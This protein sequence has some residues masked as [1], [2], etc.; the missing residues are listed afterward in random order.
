MW[1]LVLSRSRGA[2]ALG[3]GKESGVAEAELSLVLW[4]IDRTLLYVGE[5]DQ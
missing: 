5:I 4:D 1:N 3:E 2:A